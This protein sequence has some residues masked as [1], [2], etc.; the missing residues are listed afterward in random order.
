MIISLFIVV[1]SEHHTCHGRIGDDGP[2]QVRLTH[3]RQEV[4]TV[5]VGPGTAASTYN[6]TNTVSHK[7]AETK[8][9][10]GCQN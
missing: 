9:T 3:E 8:S 5:G 2:H 6:N 4:K 10:H 7:Q 1:L